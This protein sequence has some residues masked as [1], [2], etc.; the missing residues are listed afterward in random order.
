MFLNMTPRIDRARWTGFRVV[1]LMTLGLITLISTPYIRVITSVIY[2]TWEKNRK[3]L[4]VT[5]FVLILL[6]ANLALH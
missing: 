1:K 6:T 3:Y 5:L 4:L 2:F